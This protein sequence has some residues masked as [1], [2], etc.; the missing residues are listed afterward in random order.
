LVVLFE[1]S[2]AVV[3]LVIAAVGLSLTEVTGNGRWDGMASVLIGLLLAAVAW[4]LAVE[5]KALL[6]GESASREE[7][8]MIRAVTFSIEEVD[9][10]GRLLT[11]QMSPDEILVNM[12]VAFDDGLTTDELEDAIARLEVAIGDAVPS[13][14]G[15]F[16]E[17]V[18]G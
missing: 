8:S 11:M 16:I 15:I 6:I 2:A 3:G 1:D 7:R 14:K 18:S 4:F 12:D 9:H 13:V 17:P 10:I 5:M